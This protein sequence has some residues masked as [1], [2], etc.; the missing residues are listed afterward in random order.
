MM[1]RSL[2]RAKGGVDWLVAVLCT[3][4]KM[5]R[6]GGRIRGGQDRR[7]ARCCLLCPPA[8]LLLPAF[9][10]IQRSWWCT[11]R[12]RLFPRLTIHFSTTLV[13]R[14]RCRGGGAGETG[15]PLNA[16]HRPTDEFTVTRPPPSTHTHTRSLP[17]RLLHGGS[18]RSATWAVCRF[19]FYFCISLYQSLSLRIHT[20][21]AYTTK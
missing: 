1:P 19:P 5:T 18:S 13:S 15:Q 17:Q 3:L 9:F 14:G 12:R 8:P 10:C 20:H 11:I 2:A 16:T 7:G 6:G 21:L 4:V